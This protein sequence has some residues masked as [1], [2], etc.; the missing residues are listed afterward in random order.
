MV[1]NE[2][3]KFESL[4]ARNPLNSIYKL[5]EVVNRSEKDANKVA[6][7]LRGIYQTWMQAGQPSDGVPID[8]LKGKNNVGIA[9][10]HLFKLKIRR[11]MLDKMDDYKWGESSATIKFSIAEATRDHMTWEARCKDMT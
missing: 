2:L 7:V 4:G 11:N 3:F 1:Q 8:S 10:L 6:W 9:D 5:K